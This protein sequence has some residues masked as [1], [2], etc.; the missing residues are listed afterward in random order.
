MTAALAREFAK[1][2]SVTVLTSH[3]KNFLYDKSDNGLR[4]VKVPVLF[5]R[6]KSAAN[7]L[8]MAAYIPAGIRAGKKLLKTAGFDVVNTVFVLPSGPV[9]QALADLGGIP[10]VLSVLGGDLYDPSKFTSPHRHAILRHW[11]RRLL[12]RADCVVGQSQNI[13]ENVQKYYAPEVP[14]TLIPL[15][16]SRPTLVP[17]SRSIYGFSEDEILL[18]TVGRLVERKAVHQLLNMMEKWPD[19]KV[20]LLIIGDGPLQES[21]KRECQEK[22]LFD[23]VSFMGFV[24][25]SEKFKLLQLSD[26]FVSTSQHEGFGLVFVEAMHCGLP[27]VCYDHGGQTDFLTDGKTGFVVS[28]NNETLFKQRCMELASSRS[29]RNIAGTANRKLAEDYDIV[30]CAAR[31]EEVFDKVIRARKPGNHN[32]T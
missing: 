31:Y 22:Q 21:L 19:Q 27:I 4:I 24:S 2:H 6:I 28:L 13:L 11:V 3:S 26:V 29:S 10:N 23:R 32:R 14:G 30:G 9:G 1:R 15:G 25:E 7:I 5:R 20:R 12:R 17:A 8:S 16:I 18:V